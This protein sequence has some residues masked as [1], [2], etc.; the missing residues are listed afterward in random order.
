[1][2]TG[3][4]GLVLVHAGGGVQVCPNT[5][6]Q[7]RKLAEARGLG[8]ARVRGRDGVEVRVPR[9]GWDRL[10]HCGAI[11]PAAHLWFGLRRALYILSTTTTV[12]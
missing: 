1:M 2:Q 10:S 8:L 5:C 12:P 4:E 7:V 6:H 9:V 11:K 3:N